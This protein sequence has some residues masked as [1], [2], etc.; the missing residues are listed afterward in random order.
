VALARALAPE[1]AL[2]LLD[3]PFSNLDAALRIGTRREIRDILRAHG[4]GAVF[5]THDQEEALSFA[6]RVAVMRGGRIEQIGAPEE[7]YARPHNAFVAG[8]LG[9]TNLVP[10]DARDSIAL[11]AFGEVRLAA[12]A[13][14]P[15]LLSL[16]PE[17][18]AL[19]AAP[20]EG[21][22]GGEVVAREFKGHDVTLWVRH[23]GLDLQVDTEALSPFRPGDRVRIAARA[24]AVVVGSGGEPAPG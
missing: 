20:R 23:N 1:P 16:R 6:D 22:A 24:A 8:F 5:V 12:P 2:L 9:R 17:Q 15:V 13:S 18:L 3:E 14:G 19:D 11:T 7:V 4:V 10:A 21:D